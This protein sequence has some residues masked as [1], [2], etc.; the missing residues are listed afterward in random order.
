MHCPFCGGTKFVRQDVDH[1]IY[2]GTRIIGKVTVVAEV[3]QQCG[4]FFYDEGAL[5]VID[6]AER[7]LKAQ[8][9]ASSSQQ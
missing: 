7:N 8:V 9:V 4:E 2:S 3:C 1:P 5:K 6:E